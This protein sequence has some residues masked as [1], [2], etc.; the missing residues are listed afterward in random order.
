LAL[1]GVGRIRGEDATKF[2]Q[3]DRRLAALADR[4]H[5]RVARWQL[6]ALGYGPDAI[7]YRVGIGRLHA[8]HQGVYAVGH[9][10]STAKSGWISAVLACGPEAVLS[11]RHAAALWELRGSPTG[12]VHVTV[13]SRNG[14]NRPGIKIHRA[15][16]LLPEERTEIDGIPVTSLARTLLD[17]AEDTTTLW[18]ERAFETADRRDLLDLNAI[19]A[20]LERSPGRRGRQRLSK[21]VD[22]YRGPGP[23]LRSELERRFWRL[24]EEAGLPLPLTNV[25]VE[26]ELVDAYWPNERLVVELDGYGYHRTRRDFENDRERDRILELAR[27]Q[28]LRITYDRLRHKPHAAVQDVRVL[29][30][31]G[32]LARSGR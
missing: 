5:G 6:L 9:T 1:R 8:V 14:R 25:V 16:Q 19:E 31:R 32:A 13:P 20:Q 28:R 7:K 17:Y 27:V 26:G 3:D 15:S 29:L 23:E 12:P 24:I 2:D 4:Q 10:G 21:L 30:R 11:H 22:G 18:L